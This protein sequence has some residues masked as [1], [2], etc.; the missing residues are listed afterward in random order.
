MIV[1]YGEHES[2]DAQAQSLYK[3]LSD[4]MPHLFKVYMISVTVLPKPNTAPPYIQL[5][6]VSTPDGLFLIW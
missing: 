3:S 6:L 5:T 4:H 2:S 1:K